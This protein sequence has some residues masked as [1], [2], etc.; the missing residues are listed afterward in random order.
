MYAVYK[1]AI[2][3]YGKLQLRVATVVNMQLYNKLPQERLT[4]RCHLYSL[5]EAITL[6][7]DRSTLH[8]QSDISASHIRTI[9]TLVLNDRTNEIAI[10]SYELLH[11]LVRVALPLSH[12][13]VTCT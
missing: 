2:Y 11:N 10:T 6:A 13:S 9:A 12:G 5:Y 4:I 3:K 8:F 1:V 7:I